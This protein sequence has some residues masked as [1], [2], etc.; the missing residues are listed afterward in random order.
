MATTNHTNSV[1]ERLRIWAYERYGSVSALCRALGKV[2][3][4][5]NPYLAGRSAPGAVLLHQ[6]E[7]LGCNTDWL[8]TGIGTMHNDA[9]T[10]DAQ[11]RATARATGHQ[12]TEQ[13]ETSTEDPK[14]EQEEDAVE[15]V[16]FDSRE[17]V[18][19]LKDMLRITI[20][21]IS[22]LEGE[23]AAY[24]T[25]LIRYLKD[26]QAKHPDEETSM[27]LS[28]IDEYMRRLHKLYRMTDGKTLS[29]GEH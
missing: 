15:Q 26:L 11:A 1:G 10:T 25:S 9:H 7:Q 2:T 8:L 12:S 22:E 14:S 23:Y 27:M 3:S 18:M 17:D 5:L 20:R 6:L 28:K 19:L 29:T 21:Q 4:Y 13:V 24:H 16:V